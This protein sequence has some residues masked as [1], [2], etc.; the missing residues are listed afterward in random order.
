M[1]DPTD[2]AAAAVADALAETL[3]GMVTGFVT[4]VGWVDVDG[5][6]QVTSLA[7]DDQVLTTSAGLLAVANAQIDAELGHWVSGEDSP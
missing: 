1:I 5:D 2:M 7:A 6:Q 3:P 4:I